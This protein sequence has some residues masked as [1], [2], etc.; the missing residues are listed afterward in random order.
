MSLHIAAGGYRHL[1]LSLTV[2]CN[3]PFQELITTMTHVLLLSTY[4]GHTVHVALH[5]IGS[6]LSLHSYGVKLMS[7]ATG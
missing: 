2:L 5:V 1:S 7:V 4:H 6:S 3:V